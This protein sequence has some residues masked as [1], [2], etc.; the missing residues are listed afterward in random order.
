MEGAKTINIGVQKWF[1][2]AYFVWSGQLSLQSFLLD[3][4]DPGLSVTKR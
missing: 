1:L 4:G 2:G 3:M